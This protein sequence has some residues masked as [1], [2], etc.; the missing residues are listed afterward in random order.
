MISRHLVLSLACTLAALVVPISAQAQGLALAADAINYSGWSTGGAPMNAVWT[1][2]SGSTPALT[3][4]PSPSTSSFFT[5][6]NAVITGVVDHTFINDFEIEVNAIH[7]SYSKGLWI[8]MFNAAGTQGYAMLWDSAL[9]TQYSSQGHVSI[10]KY[11][12]A[13][14]GSLVFN[15]ANTILGSSTGS[16]HNSGNTT[17]AAITPPFAR[18]KLTW[19]NATDTL[20]LYVNG[21][22]KRTVTDSSFSSFSRICIGGGTGSKFDNLAVRL[23]GGAPVPFIT[24]EAEAGATNGSVVALTGLPPANTVTPEIEASGR[25]YVELNATGEYVEFKTQAAANALVVRHCTPDAATGG[26]SNSTLSLYV[27]GTLRQSLALSSKHNWLYGAAGANGQSNTPSAGVPHVFWTE[28]RFF[29]TGAALAVGDTVRLQKTSS[30]TASYYRIDSVDL[31]NVA[32]PLAPPPAGTYL[33]VTDAPYNANGADAADDTTAIANCIAAAKTQGKSVWIPA[34]TYYQSA[35]FA[36]N[37]V[38]IRGAGMW[39]TT[40]I[41]TAASSG[42]AGNTGFNLAGNGSKVY[43]MAI[44]DQTN[45]NR[46]TGSKAFTGYQATNWVVENVWITN[47][48]CGFWMSKATN[49]VVRGCRVRGTYADAINLNRGASHNLVENCHVRGCGDDGA[50]ILSEDGDVEIATNNTLRYNTILANWW[51]HNCDLAGG[52]GHLIEYNYW[53]DNVGSGVFTINLPGSYPMHPIT[54]G[55]VRRNL[56]VRGGGNGSGQQRGAM[57]IYPGSTTISNL[58]VQDNY[59]ADSI[60]R[61]IHLTGSHSQQIHFDRNTIDH[62]ATDGFFIGSSVVG[63]GNFTGNIVKSLNSGREQFNNDA[64]AGSYTVT[65]SGNSW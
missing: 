21:V 14:L 55:T 1:L 12:V 8:G 5:L 39:H 58:L 32:G 31:E 29:I 50:A 62:P 61:G 36:A 16:G 40:L 3:A 41:G 42:F 43:D 64:P 26:G 47:M 48:N 9:A 18:L 63:S 13:S 65:Q 52:G 19:N 27:N 56:L 37:G 22:L 46:N 24:H 20:N 59:I 17:S 2:N 57:W 23:P 51:G 45:T 53:A 25:A 6:S 7:T 10:R 4:E 15:S 11:S 60:F 33:S 49:G 30:N 34:G 54:G 44:T 38:T 28:H 35:L